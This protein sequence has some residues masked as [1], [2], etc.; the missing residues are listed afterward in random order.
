M[1]HYLCKWIPPRSDFLAT[2]SEDEKEWM[3]QH[4]AFLNDLLEKGVIVAHGPVMNG[5]GG[6]GVSLY[7]IP[8]DEDIA[9][10]TSQDPVIK[11]GVGHYEHFVML[12]LTSRS[13]YPNRYLIQRHFS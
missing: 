1:K 8:D 13:S 12:H 10:F 11:H 3:T 6:Y 4:G 7:S 2:M 5:E 9:A